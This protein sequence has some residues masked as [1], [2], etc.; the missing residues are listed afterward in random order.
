MGAP[1]GLYRPAPR[2]YNGNPAGRGSQPSVSQAAVFSADY[3]GPPTG[4]SHP[5]VG[6]D[7]T[8]RV[9]QDG[10]VGSRPRGVGQPLPRAPHAINQTRQGMATVIIRQA[11][12]LFPRPHDQ[13]S[14][15][16]STATVPGLSAGPASQRA[17]VVGG[18][19]GGL[20]DRR[21]GPAPNR[22]YHCTPGG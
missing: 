6:V 15:I 8:A 10:P 16:R 13:A 1:G 7:K 19:D 12:A 14:V 21:L 11:A 5:S 22:F 18:E 2:G 3:W 17:P 9:P 20:R 4:G